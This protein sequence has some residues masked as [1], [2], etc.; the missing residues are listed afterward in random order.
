MTHDVL[1]IQN[2]H[3]TKFGINRFLEKLGF[4]IQLKTDQKVAVR[5]LLDGVN[6]LAIYWST[7]FGKS[8]IFQ[9]LLWLVKWQAII[10]QQLWFI[11]VC[12]VF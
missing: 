9:P 8:L 4:E 12:L 5:C 1:Y 3:V 7:D 10:K 2:T 11:S 6:V